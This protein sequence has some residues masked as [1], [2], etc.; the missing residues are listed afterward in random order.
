[1]QTSCRFVHRIGRSVILLAIAASAASC[2]GKSMVVRDGAI[3]TGGQSGADAAVGGQA[4]SSVASDADWPAIPGTGGKAKGTGGAFLVGSGGATTGGTMGTVDGGITFD[5]GPRDGQDAPTM[6][7]LETFCTGEAKATR[8]GVIAAAP[9]T[10]YRMDMAACCTARYGLLFQT[11][12]T[13]GSDGEIIIQ[14]TETTL[15]QGEYL[16]TN[17]WYPVGVSFRFADDAPDTWQLASGTL[18][19]TGDP[20]GTEPF[21]LGL[22]VQG[23]S[24]DRRTALTWFYLPGISIAPEAWASRFRISLLEDSK[25]SSTDAAKQ[26]LDSLVLAKQPLLDMARISSVNQATGEIRL[27][28]NGDFGTSI[29]SQLENVKQLLMPFVVEAE[30]ARIYLGSFVSSLSSSA[31]PGPF[32]DADRIGTDRFRIE[33]G[34]TGSDPR[35][36]ARI[37][38]V[39]TEASRMVQ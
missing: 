5:G 22:C 12:E 37:L 18:R 1:M 10:A 3:S 25:L 26:S 36:D 19:I 8:D 7:S 2:G 16:L 17:A 20:A 29:R 28:G 14:Q 35:W 33:N 21:Q 27:Q 32:V 34:F 4:G 39:L 30:G 15:A 23:A 11:Q 38:K 13:L 9:I 31:G 6:S 24:S